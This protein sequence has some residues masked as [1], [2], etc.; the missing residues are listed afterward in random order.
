M[1]HNVL[2]VEISPNLTIYSFAFIWIY[3]IWQFL[4]LA[5]FEAIS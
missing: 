2:N 4:R 3:S 1:G 5:I